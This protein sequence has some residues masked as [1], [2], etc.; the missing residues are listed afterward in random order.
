M[1]STTMLDGEE[2]FVFRWSLDE[3]HLDTCMGDIFDEPPSRSDNLDETGLDT[4][5]DSFG[6]PNGYSKDFMLENV[7]HLWTE[8]S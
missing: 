6:Y 7:S 5:G 8:Q 3:I 4:N 1:L 2:N